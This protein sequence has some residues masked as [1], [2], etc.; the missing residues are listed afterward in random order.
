MFLPMDTT[1]SES[2]TDTDLLEHL[3]QS[4][5]S[6]SLNTLS[7][8]QILSQ[9]DAEIN[10]LNVRETTGG[11]NIWALL[12]VIFG[13][14]VLLL[15]H[16]ETGFAEPVKITFWFL[17]LSLLSDGAISWFI[18]GVSPLLKR[19][20]EVR[21]RSAHFFR[22][23]RIFFAAALL[24]YVGLMVAAHTTGQSL[25]QLIPGMLFGVPV[26][27]Y[28]VKALLA[29]R[30]L[31][32]TWSPFTIQDHL[33]QAD[34]LRV[35]DGVQD[36]TIIGSILMSGIAVNTA[37]AYAQAAG[38]P[39]VGQPVSSELQVAALLVVLTYAVLWLLDL[40]FR[41]PLSNLLLELRRD[42]AFGRISTSAAIRKMEE[43][44]RGE[45][46]FASIIGSD[47]ETFRD[48]ARKAPK[49]SPRKVPITQ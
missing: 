34:G 9:I 27:Y 35:I 12:G 8:D 37:Y 49:R 13:I 31:V 5:P 24:R 39:V 15:P 47:R 11:W 20:M 36:G 40:T 38:L 18:P 23:R 7:V 42:L 41:P 28:F 10:H 43:V 17:C 25:E 6:S 45:P 22:H 29:L 44:V 1:A 2:I 32:L 30:L 4:E 33:G 14:V 26:A 16:W 48:Y 3:L 21:E 19:H 46:S